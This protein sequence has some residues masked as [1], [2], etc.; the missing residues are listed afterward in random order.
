MTTGLSDND[1]QA[2]VDSDIRSLCVCELI[3]LDQKGHVES[4]S[5]TLLL[6]K[7]SKSRESCLLSDTTKSFN[8]KIST[9][10][11]VF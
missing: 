3:S 5:V 1:K 7:E 10:M 2:R 11:W 4:L 6:D 8:A 9:F